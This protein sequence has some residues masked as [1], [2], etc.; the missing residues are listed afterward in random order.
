MFYLVTLRVTCLLSFQNF[1]RQ[2]VHDI[3]RLKPQGRIYKRRL[4][5]HTTRILFLD[6]KRFDARASKHYNQYVKNI[7]TRR[8]L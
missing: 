1:Q 8:L 2:H 7:L 5:P 6:N 3:H 4:V